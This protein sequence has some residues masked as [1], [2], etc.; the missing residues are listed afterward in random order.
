MNNERY[1]HIVAPMV[2]AIVSLNLLGYQWFINVLK[3]HLC[4]EFSNN[5]ALYTQITNY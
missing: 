3:Y 1:Y 5:I 2:H 4:Q